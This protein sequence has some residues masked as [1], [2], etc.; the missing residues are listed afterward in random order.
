[1]DLKKSMAI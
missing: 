1:M